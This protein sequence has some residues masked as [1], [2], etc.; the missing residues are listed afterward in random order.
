MVISSVVTAELSH[1]SIEL[2]TDTGS[3]GAG[4]FGLMLEGKDQK[5]LQQILN[6]LWQ[7]IIELNGTSL[8]RTSWGWVLCTLYRE[9]FLFSEVINVL[10][11]CI[12]WHAVAGRK[13]TLV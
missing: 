2:S 5:F 9:G 12:M 8:L 1:L 7:I 10:S 4:P 3:G 11:T 6:N 13:R